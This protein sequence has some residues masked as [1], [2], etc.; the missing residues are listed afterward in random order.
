[1]IDIPRLTV[2]LS[3]QSRHVS[4]VAGPSLR[5]ILDA[6]DMR[7]RS[8]CRGNGLCGLCVVRILQ[9]PVNAPTATEHLMLKAAQLAQGLRLACQVAPQD[10]LRV[11][12]IQAAAASKWRALG[13][14]ALP[15]GP[16]EVSRRSD[17]SYGV[18]IDLGTTH[19]SMA[20]WDLQQ[21][22]RLAGRVGKNPQAAFGADVM[23]RLVAA[24]ESSG[25]AR[26]MSQMALDAIGEALAD[27]CSRHGVDSRKIARLSIVG[28]TPMLAILTQTTPEALLAPASWTQPM[29]CPPRDARAWAAA[30]GLHAQAVVEVVDPLAGFV[31]S[32]LLAGVLAARLTDQPASLLVDFGTNSEIALWDGRCLWATSAAG[33][34]AFEG[35]GIAHGMPAEPGAIHRVAWAGDSADIVYQVLDGAEPKGICGSGLVDLIA[36]LIGRGKLTRTGRFS[37]AQAEGFV[38]RREEPVITLD[39][40]GVDLFQ[41]AKAAIGVGIIALL[42]AAGMQAGQLRRV[43]V[44]GAFGQYLDVGNAQAIG[45]LPRVAPQRVE[46]CGNTAL[47]G[48]ER[49]IVAPDAAAELAALRRNAMIVNLAQVQDFDMMFLHCLYLQPLEINGT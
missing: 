25:D 46:L 44:C 45:L 2:I 8:G 15:L 38:V 39:G 29:P 14:A 21:G 1:M 11:E 37:G 23:T 3:G 33:G 5:D 32:D 41:R 19:I 43:C 22:V 7:V 49:L 12:L 9:G 16:V 13:G 26:T 35:S 28:N 40:R 27:I 17:E 18:A 30:L 31:G 10:D 24:S 47:A 48:C 36:C 6:T 20:L 4:F 42:K 34:P